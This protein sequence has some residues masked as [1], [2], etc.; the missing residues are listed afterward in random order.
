MLDPGWALR[1]SRLTSGKDILGTPP[2]D[3]SANCELQVL[4]REVNKEKIWSF[5][6]IFFHNGENVSQRAEI[7]NGVCGADTVTTNYVQFWFRRFRS[8][9]FEFKDAPRTGRLVIENVDK[10]TEI[11]EVDRHVRV[12]VSPMS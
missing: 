11:I 3:F 9:I 6:Q 4:K 12:V 8:G 1:R 5:L 7:A 2:E 10:I